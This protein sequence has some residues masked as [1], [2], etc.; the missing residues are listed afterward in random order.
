M[1]VESAPGHTFLD[2]VVEA[3]EHTGRYNRNDQVVP[4]AVR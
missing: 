2:A 1:M 4:A 3:I